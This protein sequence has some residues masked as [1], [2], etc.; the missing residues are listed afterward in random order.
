MR[1]TGHARREHRKEL[2]GAPAVVLYNPSIAAS[3][4][5]WVVAT[6]R[7]AQSPTRSWTGA[8]SAAM[9]SGMAS[10]VRS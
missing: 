9:V 2:A 5:G 4:V 1:A 10:A 8:A 3:L 7:A 6:S